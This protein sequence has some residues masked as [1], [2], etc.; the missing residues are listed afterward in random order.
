MS[1][2]NE[3]ELLALSKRFAAIRE[4]IEMNLYLQLSTLIY[5]CFPGENRNLTNFKWLNAALLTL[6]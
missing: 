3:G 6:L 5:L 2:W 4:M 1:V